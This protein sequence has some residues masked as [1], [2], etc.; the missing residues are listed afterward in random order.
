MRTADQ[1]S[2]ACG[3]Q[4]ETS[5]MDTTWSAGE[6]RHVSD[7]HE[8]CSG[9]VAL[10]IR[11]QRSTPPRPRHSPGSMQ[12]GWHPAQDGHGGRSACPVEAVRSPAAKARPAALASTW[13]CA[14]STEA[15]AWA[16]VDSALLASVNAPIPCL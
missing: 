7:A 5:S 15:C 6:G 11:I 3:R 14:S 10:N 1:A 4:T 8:G 2:V 12:G 16:S 9:Q 13:A